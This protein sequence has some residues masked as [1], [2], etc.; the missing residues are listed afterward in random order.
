M[1]L[2]RERTEVSSLEVLQQNLAAWNEPTHGVIVGDKFRYIATSNWPA[3]D[4]KGAL[5][6]GAQLQALRIMTV[7]LGEN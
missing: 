2:N 5:K 6:D 3:Y 7:R 4:D 1:N